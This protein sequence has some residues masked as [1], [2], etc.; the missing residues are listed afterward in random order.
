MFARD[1]AHVSEDT[2]DHIIPVFRGPAETVEC[3]LHYTLGAFFCVWVTNRRSDNGDFVVRKD[4]VTKG[5][6]AVTL[7][8]NLSFLYRTTGEEAK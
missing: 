7:L 1:E 4:C 5:V 6:F 8:E 3:L 2:S